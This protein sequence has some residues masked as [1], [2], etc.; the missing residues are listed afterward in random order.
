MMLV[1]NG[2]CMTSLPSQNWISRPKPT[3][4]R[5]VG[6]LVPAACR[7]VLRPHV[8][9]PHTTSFGVCLFPATVHSEAWLQITVRSRPD[10][11][12]ALPM[13]SDLKEAAS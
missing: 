1:F 7:M 5:L 6:S 11:R 2:L 3:S 13:S 12:P 9:T 8:L 10:G 4:P